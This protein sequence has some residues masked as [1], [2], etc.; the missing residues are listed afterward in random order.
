MNNLYANLGLLLAGAALALL[1]A[2]YVHR[3]LTRRLK[4][5]ADAVETIA[6]GDFATPL[7]L[8]RADPNGDELDRLTVGI[9]RMSERMARQ[10]A[11]LQQAEVRR[12]E[13]IANVS[14]DLRTPLASM[15]GHLE[16]LLLKHGSL[17]P[18]EQRSYLEIATR[19][20]ERL[21]KLVRDLFQLTKLEAN[22]IVPQCE[23][24]S[25]TE[26]VQDVVQKLELAAEKRGLR[27]VSRFSVQQI[28][29]QADI[30]MIET[31]LEN[32]IGNALR[33]TPRGGQ[34]CVDVEPRARRVALR[35][36]DTGCGIAR[37]DLARLFDR[38]YHVDRGE[39]VDAAG[40]GLGLA[41][42]RRIV[43]LH[44][45]KIGVES[46]LGRGTTFAFDLPVV[47]V[48]ADPA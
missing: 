31:V 5:L 1:T 38:Y 46:T 22:E 7:E 27:L 48:V 35:V 29:V 41:I 23:A 37:E 18:A 4:R 12:R 3:R 15:Q 33:H 16:L 9:G 25:A 24:F 30:G 20:C 42:V 21:S 39:D 8:P 45:S 40:T 32:L 47:A 14:H 36:S 28:Q 43:E 11:Q 6:Q 34:I 17:P 2:L 19:H 13:L 26:L 44:G 10:L